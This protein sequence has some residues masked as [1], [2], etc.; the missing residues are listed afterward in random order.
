MTS[1]EEKVKGIIENIC[2]DFNNLPIEER[3]RINKYLSYM[4]ISTIW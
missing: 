1:L 3:K 4:Q 2:E